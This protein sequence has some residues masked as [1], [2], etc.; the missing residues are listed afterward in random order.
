MEDVIWRFV[1]ERLVGG[2]VSGQTGSPGQEQIWSRWVHP[3]GDTYGASRCCRWTGG[4]PA[5]GG[6]EF[7]DKSPSSTSLHPSLE[8]TASFTAAS[9]VG[10]TLQPVLLTCL[11]C[12]K[13]R[14]QEA[15]SGWCLQESGCFPFPSVPCTTPVARHRESVRTRRARGRFSGFDSCERD[16]NT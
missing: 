11:G 6:L 13:D 4:Q 16:A 15:P 1:F 5:W 10:G 9:P 3:V 7:W 8:P 2:A 14:S 12:S